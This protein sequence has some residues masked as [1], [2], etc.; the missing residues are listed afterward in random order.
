MQGLQPWWNITTE[1]KYVICKHNDG[2]YIVRL[3]GDVKIVWRGKTFA[4]ACTMARE[5]KQAETLR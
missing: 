3:I 5:L 1:G 4:V 2:D